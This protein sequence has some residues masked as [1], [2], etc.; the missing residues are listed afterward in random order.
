MASDC[1]AAWTWQV[2]RC[3]PSRLCFPFPPFPPPFSGR[4]SKFF[5]RT[6][7]LTPGPGSGPR[8]GLKLLVTSLFA[9]VQEGGSLGSPSVRLCPTS[10]GA[11]PFLTPSLG[12]SSPPF[13]CRN[14]CFF[15]VSQPTNEASA[16]VR[17]LPFIEL[18]PFSVFLVS[19]LV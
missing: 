7:K 6:L 3:G 4:G 19:V 13:T 12:H 17:L 16:E 18:F 11:P 1:G 5:L 14:T 8:G 15:K 2:P 9:G 10:P